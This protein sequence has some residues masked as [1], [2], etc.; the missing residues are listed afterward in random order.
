MGRESLWYLSLRVAVSPPWAAVF[1]TA[2]MGAFITWSPSAG[3]ITRALL[4]LAA[5]VVTAAG[6]ALGLTLF[7]WRVRPR[8]VQFL[9]SYAFPLLGCAVG[10]A[11]VYPFGPMLV[12]FGMFVVGTL[13]VTIREAW[14]VG[15]S[16]NDEGVV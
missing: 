15:R 5:P 1:Y 13:A 4:W 10:A 12:V 16:H 14:L 9:R 7:R 2:W 8:G 3:P 11:V 6:F